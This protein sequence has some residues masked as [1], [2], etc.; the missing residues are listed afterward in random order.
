MARKKTEKAEIAVEKESSDSIAVCLNV[1]CVALKGRNIYTID[2]KAFVSAKELSQLKEM[3][4][5]VE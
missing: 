1:D 5:V 3:G 4:V 2:G